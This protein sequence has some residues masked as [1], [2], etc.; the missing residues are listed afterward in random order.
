M[1]AGEL[2]GARACIFADIYKRALQRTRDLAIAGGTTGV[3]RD[4]RAAAAAHMTNCFIAC[5]TRL[6]TDRFRARARA[7][8]VTIDGSSCSPAV[9]ALFDK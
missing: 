8:I 9:A 4:V 2:G 6:F 5:I 7:C 1:R 3:S